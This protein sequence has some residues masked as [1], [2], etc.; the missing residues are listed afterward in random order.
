MS[1]VTSSTTSD[2]THRKVKTFRITGPFLISLRFRD[3][4]A[5]ELDFSIWAT[6]RQGPLGFPLRDL[7]FFNQVFLDHGVLTW[8]NGYDIDPSTLRYWAEQGLID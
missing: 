4:L 3:D 6:N 8:P 7:D 2:I 5:S 1:F